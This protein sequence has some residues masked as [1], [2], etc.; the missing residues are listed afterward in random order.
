VPC[1]L[2]LRLTEK[3]CVLLTVSIS[4]CIVASYREVDCLPSGVNGFVALDLAVLPAII[5]IHGK[6]HL[7]SN[8]SKIT[9]MKVEK[10]RTSAL[11]AYYFILSFKLDD[12]L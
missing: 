11:Y 6:R 7:N 4:H 5:D 1:D 2:F 9:P 8:F 10:S 12:R 3:L